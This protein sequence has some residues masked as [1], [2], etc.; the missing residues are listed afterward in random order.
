MRT[1]RAKSILL[2]LL[3]HVLIAGNYA[4]KIQGYIESQNDKVDNSGNPYQS[5]F[6][7]ALTDADLSIQNYME[8]LLLNKYSDVSFY[9]EEE[10]SSLNAKYFPKDSE[11]KITLDPIDGTLFYKNKLPLYS[12]ILNICSKK[13][14]LASCIF[15]PAIETCYFGVKDKGAYKLST[16][17]M[18]AKELGEKITLSEKTDTVLLYKSPEEKK[19]LANNY[20]AFDFAT[21]YENQKDWKDDF[22]NILNSTTLAVVTNYPLLIDSGAIAFLVKEAGGF[23][24]DLAGNELDHEKA[25]NNL[26]YDNLIMAVTEKAGRKILEIINN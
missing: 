8:L 15:K 10:D 20:F 17:N 24:S 21:D 19:K 18:E 12:V 2:D 25:I 14:I 13:E 4:N 5:A 7:E 11:L 16:A 22:A 6:T 9:G 1:E 23:V 3:P 26:K